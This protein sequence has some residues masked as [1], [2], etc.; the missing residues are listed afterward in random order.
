MKTIVFIFIVCSC[1]I[2]ASP[3]I[4]SIPL[5]NDILNLR[6]VDFTD[7]IELQLL[8]SQ[9][10]KGFI[11]KYGTHILTMLIFLLGFWRISF[12]SKK[13]TEKILLSKKLERADEFLEIFTDYMII[14]KNK[15]DASTLQAI[16]STG[17]ISLEHQRLCLKLL[18]ILDAKSL[19]E[20]KL[21]RQI[22]DFKNN[23][24][25]TKYSLWQDKTFEQGQRVYKI[26]SK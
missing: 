16:E 13:N 26:K 21:I 10:R 23:L 25:A 17:Y 24:D 5:E 7:T 4:D 6:L 12:T 1:S 8:Q 19:E 2:L 11:E 3:H 14:F 15:I 22:N 18:V 9:T 20:N